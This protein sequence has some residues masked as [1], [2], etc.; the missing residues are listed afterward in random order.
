MLQE[1]IVSE[2][3]TRV[4]GSSLLKRYGTTSLDR[5]WKGGVGGRDCAF[6][7]LFHENLNPV[8]F[9]VYPKR[10]FLQKLIKCNLYIGP[11]D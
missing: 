3:Q 9:L 7:L 2:I 11:F 8:L 5:V 4:R 1:M 6:P 10:Q